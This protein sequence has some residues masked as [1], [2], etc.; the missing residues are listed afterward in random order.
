MEPGR[1]IEEQLEMN[2]DPGVIA[3]K[4]NKAGTRTRTGRKWN[5]KYVKMKHKY[6]K[7]H[8]LYNTTKG[9]KL[10]D[11]GEDM[12]VM[13]EREIAST[14]ELVKSVVEFNHLSSGK[15]LEMIRK[16]LT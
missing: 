2:V 5:S 12:V 11:T 7:E 6:A 3:K 10:V 1:F 14:L 9:K 4:L 13:E 16:I 15:R 8:G